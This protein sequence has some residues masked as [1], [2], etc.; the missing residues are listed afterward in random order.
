MSVERSLRSTPISDQATATGIEDDSK[1]KNL[2]RAK[3]A[4]LE[5]DSH[6]DGDGGSD[7]SLGDSESKEVTPVEAFRWNVEGDQSPC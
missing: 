5:A 4:D 1:G 6:G 7:G 2:V 3:A